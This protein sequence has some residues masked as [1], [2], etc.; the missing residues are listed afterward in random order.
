MAEPI[1]LTISEIAYGG[2]GVAR[3]DGQV[4]FVPFTAPGEKIRALLTDRPGAG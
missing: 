3:H 4:I 1:E 2:D